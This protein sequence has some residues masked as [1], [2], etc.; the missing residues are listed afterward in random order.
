MAFLY[1]ACQF[2][3]FCMSSNSSC[4]NLEK[5]NIPEG[6]KI[7]KDHAFS[8]CWN[9]KSINIPSSVKEIGSQAFWYADIDEL[10]IPDGVVNIDKMAFCGCHK[11]K[12]V[13]IPESVKEIGY[14][15][16]NECESL[17]SVN[18]TK[19]TAD[20]S[21][22][23]FDKCD[24][25]SEIL[26]DEDNPRYCS[27][28]GVLFSKDK[29][30][31]IQYP[32]AKKDDFC[33]P[34]GLIKINNFPDDAN[35]I[36]KR[37]NFYFDE[38]DD[39][40]EENE[41][42]C[43]SVSG[44]GFMKAQK[45]V[46]SFYNDSTEENFKK[47]KKQMYK[48]PF[49]LLMTL[50]STEDEYFD[51][52]KDVIVF[53]EY[54]KNNIK[55]TVKYLIDNSDTENLEKLLSFGFITENII[56]DLIAYA[57]EK[58][59]IEMRDMLTLL[60]LKIYI[61]NNDVSE[62]KIPDGVV[63]I[64]K[65]AF[66]YCKSITKVI[67]PNSVTTI[68]NSAFELCS[69]LKE[70]IMTDSITKIGKEA[71]LHCDA[72]EKITIPDSVEEI[73]DD[74]FSCCIALEK[75]NI[76]DRIKKIS[77]GTFSCCWKLE[78]IEIGNGVTEIEM[79]AFDD[80]RNLKRIV[81]PDNVKIIKNAFEKCEK[82]EN[83]TLSK[84]IEFIDSCTF[85][86]CKSLKQITIPENVNRIYSNAFNNCQSL[87][88]INLPKNVHWLDS[89][90]FDGCINLENVHVDENNKTYCSVDG[91]VFTQDK[92][93]LVYYPPAKN[94]D[95]KFYKGLNDIEFLPNGKRVVFEENNVRVFVSS[96]D[97]TKI[98]K[99]ILEFNND[100]TEE[101]FKW[102]RRPQHKIPF[103]LLMTLSNPNEETVFKEYTKNNIKDTVKYLIDNG[104]TENLSKLLSLEFVTEKVISDLIAYADEKSQIEMRDMLN[105]YIPDRI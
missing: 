57:D 39:E 72:L 45:D 18:I 97:L 91:I 80:C 50:S 14:G 82:L 51:E 84:N 42:T 76:P 21:Q 6:V 66:F 1:F 77:F 103:A 53:R 89:H 5:I 96:N 46:L 81:I 68:G 38:D 41:Y 69:N 56:S 104:D 29:T 100:R 79:C 102:I 25:L 11:L 37:E 71:F 105:T 32:M 31:V 22:K 75:I 48:I 23:I 27:I 8:F 78:E 44:Q 20:F 63:T 67:I 49:A 15:A 93:V 9:L 4:Q 85:F 65:Y 10:I 83:I 64:R 2:F 19:C 90:A 87:T 7:I 28:D 34:N 74:A 3:V 54:I 40:C 94:T 36:F 26:A 98:K 24:S 88:N 92:T 95:F 17:Q 12:K 16:F 59:Q 43:V 61:L 30:E 47:L 86:N 60:A 55:D 73:G 58:S 33:V 35:L 70:V 99:V 62:V 13:V 52:Y 101:N